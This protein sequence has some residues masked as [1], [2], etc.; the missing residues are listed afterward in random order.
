MYL[1]CMGA[2][3]R[4]R[5]PIERSRSGRLERTPTLDFDTSTIRVAVPRVLSQAQLKTI[6]SCMVS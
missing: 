4:L 5:D 2:Q 3:K 1:R 6:L